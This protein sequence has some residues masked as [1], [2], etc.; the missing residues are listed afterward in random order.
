MRF[1]LNLLFIFTTTIHLLSIIHTIIFI[2]NCIS[3]TI[4]MYSF[5]E[6]IL[7]FILWS[8]SSRIHLFGPNGIG[9]TTFLEEIANSTAK[10]TTHTHIHM[11]MYIHMH[12]HTCIHTHIHIRLHIHAHH[13]YYH[14][15]HYYHQYHY[16]HHYYYYDHQYCFFHIITGVKAHSSAN[17]GYYRQDFNTLDFDASGIKC[18][19]TTCVV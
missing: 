4:K 1:Y 19:Y 2:K 9:K 10:G 16:Y 13:Y 15:Y 17:I 7:P 11:N 6:L 8:N 5:I 3:R 14:H 18:K 12:S